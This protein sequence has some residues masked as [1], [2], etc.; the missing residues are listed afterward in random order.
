VIA[1]RRTSDR[2]HAEQVIGFRRICT[3]HTAARVVL[4]A[5][6]YEG[7]S[8]P[9]VLAPT[10]LGKMGRRLAEIAAMEPQRR[11]VDLY[12]ALAEVAR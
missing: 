8:T 7:P 4:D 1:I 9:T 6:H 3:R 12:A 10:P 2:L 5:R 11:P